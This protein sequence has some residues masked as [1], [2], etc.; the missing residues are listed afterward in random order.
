MQSELIN[1]YT[2]LLKTI[3]NNDQI[4]KD[5]VYKLVD[6]CFKTNEYIKEL[7]EKLLYS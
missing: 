2:V 4:T 3:G 5:L 7:S 6:N 1:L